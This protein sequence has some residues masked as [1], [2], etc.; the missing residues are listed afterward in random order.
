[1]YGFLKIDQDGKPYEM[2]HE[3]HSTL[4]RVLDREEQLK[5]DRPNSRYQLVE[6]VYKEA[7]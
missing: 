7:E 1:M 5:A 6:I 3:I 2:K 4:E